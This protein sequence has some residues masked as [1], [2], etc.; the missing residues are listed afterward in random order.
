ML[1]III[2]FYLKSSCKD[3]RRLQCENGFTNQIKIQCM[4]KENIIINFTYVD[5]RCSN[6]IINVDK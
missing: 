1:K 4:F 5:R 3:S 2:I 6:Y